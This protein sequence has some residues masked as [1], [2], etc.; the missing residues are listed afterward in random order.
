V[1]EE[2]ASIIETFRP[3]ELPCST[4]IDTDTKT[5][6]SSA[7]EWPAP[8]HD[9]YESEEEKQGLMDLFRRLWK[10]WRHYWR[11]GGLCYARI[12]PPR[13]V[14]ARFP[15]SIDVSNLR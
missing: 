2:N 8:I 9:H 15:R 10:G 11:C 7:Q 4:L 5:A 6:T 13:V 3:S 14:Q 1:G 12:F